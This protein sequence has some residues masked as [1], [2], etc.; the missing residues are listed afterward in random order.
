MNKSPLNSLIVSSKS[1]KS[2]FFLWL[3][4]K[5]L[6][7]GNFLWKGIQDTPIL[8]TILPENGIDCPKEVNK[9]K[10]K[11]PVIT[12]AL[13]STLQNPLHCLLHLNNLIW[14]ALPSLLAK[15]VK[16]REG[17]WRESSPMMMMKSTIVA[18]SL[19]MDFLVKAA[20]EREEDCQRKSSSSPT[21][22]NPM[23]LITNGVNEREG[24]HQRQLWVKLHQI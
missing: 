17:G 21:M 7:L 3:T 23:S 19:F 14:S 10:E 8:R 24:D 6:S 22:A 4:F 2:C 1:P 16:E 11:K 9:E 5:A 15:V 18:R 20:K 12:T 13:F